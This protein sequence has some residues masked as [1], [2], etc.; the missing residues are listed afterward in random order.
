MFEMLSVDIA[1]FF[2]LIA[3]SCRERQMPVAD[4][5]CCRTDHVIT[6]EMLYTP[7][8]RLRDTFIM[9]DIYS[10]YRFNFSEILRFQMPFISRVLRRRFRRRLLSIRYFAIISR[11]AGAFRCYALLRIERH[12]RCRC[13]I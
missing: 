6:A 3:A 12:A 5:R 7:C 10:F 8:R 11:D 9:I 2:M 1:A 4:S 13:H